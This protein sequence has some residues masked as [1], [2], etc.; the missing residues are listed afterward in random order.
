MKND[1]GLV[2]ERLKEK[3]A[4]LISDFLNGSEPGFLNRH[5]QVLDDYFRESFENSTVGPGMAISKNP[6]A[7]IALGG[8]GR[9]E[10]CIHS[11]IDLLFLFE[12]QV[13]GAAEDLI[14]EIIYPLWD[15][16]LEVG[17]ATRS[18]KECVALAGRDFEVL[19]PLLDA[20]FVCGMSHLY[21][22]LW[23]SLRKKV[24]L[25][26]G[27]KIITWLLEGNRDRHIRF[28]DS[29]YL[30]EPNL[31]EGQG[32]LRDYHTMLWVG[33]I[34]Y[35]LMQPRDL[36]YL[37]CL[38][39]NEYQELAEALS[40][41]WGVRNRLH[42]LSGRK[43]DQLHFE[44]QI[45]LAD[46]LK[47]TARNGQQPVER[48]LGKLHGKMAFVK[49]Q[50][51]MFLYELG[52]ARKLKPGKKPVRQIDIEGLH[53][54][55][56]MLNFN[57]SEDILL[58]PDLL[59]NI[60]RA[61][62]RKGIPLS[63]EARR[64]VR[65]FAYLVDDD[66][67]NSDFAI[68]AF[69][70]ILVTRTPGFDVLGE[71]MST[72]FLERFIPE[73]KSIINRIQYDEYHFYP[74]DKHSLHTVQEIKTFGT[75]EDEAGDSLPGT[76][77]GELAN[78]KLLLWAALL[79]DIGKGEDGESHS[80]RGAEIVRAVLERK[81]YS[82]E[83]VDT[84]SFLV[85]E[86]LLLVKAATRR[87][88][89]DE[90][91]AILCAKRI[92]DSERLKMLYLLTVA[93]S[94]STGPKA[95][96]EWV[97]TLLKDLFLKVLNIIEKGELATREAEEVVERKKETVIHSALSSKSAREMEALFQ[98]MSPRY[99]LYAPEKDIKDHIE[100]Y[101][102]LGNADFVWNVA[103]TPDSNTRRITICAKDRP[104]LF[105]K[106]AGTFTLNNLNI[107]DVQVFTWRNNIA[108][109]I[110]EVEPP[111]DQLF[112][113]EIWH[114]AEKQ[115]HVALAGETDLA[116]AL[117]EKMTIYR[118]K[119]R[120][121]G[122]RPNRIVVDN[123]SSSFFTIVEVFAYDFPGLLYSITDALF[124]CRLDIWVAKI[125]TKVDQVVDV[126]YVRDFDGQKVDS[127][128][129]VAAIKTAVEAVLPTAGY[130][131]GRME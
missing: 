22:T 24:V 9:E 129:Q 82:A 51:M 7:I 76:L 72:G 41:I 104:G 131:N 57:S 17:Y 93:D 37:G 92:K 31:K 32:G 78:K 16:G 125:A 81:G 61:C 101:Q 100:L 12:K 40:F 80:K 8:Y 109:D 114:R 39:H 113:T 62:V 106:I 23:E 123:S 84:V 13:P 77:Y 19:M 117:D 122:E 99:L 50:Q 128:D 43:C 70:Q 20:R 110:F 34:E 63:A 60:F 94:I 130:G 67:S 42:C 105:S 119:R 44:Y 108:L 11:D 2:S 26:R 25:K 18:L 66:F 89:N 47:F 28:G 116:G 103:E 56:E 58:S 97:S 1:R 38:S 5:A 73:F 55:K 121:P 53:V 6:Y 87:D 33:R 91:T 68:K 71:M 64:L 21:S 127:P 85:E 102:R 36:E 118:S 35:N 111:P 10:Q 112:E 27:G 75:D 3:T 29:T 115:L 124:R 95:W 48:F 54:D 30:L 45:E 107:L 126:F 49:E 79:H 46:A 83:H 74:V 59:I 98:V 88:I 52:L 15:I 120:R 69:E 96:N 14:R 4:Q 86:H 90:E 65:E